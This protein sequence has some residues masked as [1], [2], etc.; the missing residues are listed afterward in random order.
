MA[1]DKVAVA[2]S[3]VSVHIS[4]AD[5]VKGPDGNEFF[6]VSSRVLGPGEFVRLDQ[7]PRY[8]REKVE[9]GDNRALRVMSQDDAEELRAQHGLANAAPE[10]VLEPGQ[11]AIPTDNSFS[12][13]LVADVER[14]A[15]HYQR[16]V[17]ESGEEVAPD[18][19]AAAGVTLEDAENSPAQSGRRTRGKKGDTVEETVEE[20]EKN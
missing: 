7:L 11:S 14:A 18:A 15:N 13:H 9:A 20:D 6:S 2:V 4:E 8:E 1:E 17:E 19:A 5:P 3:D 12:D 10:V 16:A